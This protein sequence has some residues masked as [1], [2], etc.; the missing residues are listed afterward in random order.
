MSFRALCV[1]L[2]ILVGSQTAWALLAP[3]GSLKNF[4]TSWTYPEPA[5]RQL[6][7]ALEVEGSKFL[8]GHWFNGW[9]E[10]R[11]SGTTDSL[12][13]MT[14]RLADCPGVTLAVVFERSEQ[15]GDWRLSFAARERQIQI[16]VNL[17]SENVVLAKLQIPAARGPELESASDLPAVRN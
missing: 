17:K 4:S 6:Q 15:P 13:E 1:G 11:F 12:N 2:S 8:R 10:L 3:I 16:L 14:R 7:A 5:R 9:I